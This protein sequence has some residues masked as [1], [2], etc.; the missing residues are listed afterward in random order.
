MCDV[1][2]VDEEVEHA[3]R[4]REV[5]GVLRVVKDLIVPLV[6]REIRAVVEADELS[7][8]ALERIEQL[9]DK[10]PE[11]WRMRQNLGSNEAIETPPALEPL[12]PRDPRVPPVGTVLLRF[13]DLHNSPRRSGRKLG[14]ER[15]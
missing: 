6:L 14:D 11:R 15:I 9:G 3:A 7:R 1:R 13:S 10:M 12:E 8:G 2:V 4:V 5:I